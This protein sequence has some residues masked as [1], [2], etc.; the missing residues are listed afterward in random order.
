MLDRIS[1]LCEFYHLT[2]YYTLGLHCH[3][4]ILDTAVAG[5]LRVT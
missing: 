5:R 3:V 2:S 4:K 1:H